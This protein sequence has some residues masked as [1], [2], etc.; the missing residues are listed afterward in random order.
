M[1]IEAILDGFLPVAR[2]ERLSSVM[3]DILARDLLNKAYGMEP[4]V[5]SNVVMGAVAL[6]LA[7]FL[8]V[9]L[10]WATTDRTGIGADRGSA[11]GRVATIGGDDV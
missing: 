6:L 8:T 2:S 4:S 7:L 5:R 1:R 9:T 3:T 11:F 10:I